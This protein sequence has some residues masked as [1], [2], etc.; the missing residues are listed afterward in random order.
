MKKEKQLKSMALMSSDGACDADRWFG[1][2]WVVA[3]APACP[4]HIASKESG[5]D[6]LAGV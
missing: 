1:S 6:G 3:T 2:V 5:V 4:A